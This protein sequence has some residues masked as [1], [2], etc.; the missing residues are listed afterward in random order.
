MKKI[1]II[2]LAIVVAAIVFRLGFSKYNQNMKIKLAMSKPAPNVVAEPV[3]EHSIIRTFE[4]PG[5]VTS[6]YQVNVLARIAGYLEKSYFK[7]GDFVKEGQTLFLIEPTE[8][9]NAA[10][11]AKAN[12]DNIH[13]QLIYAEKQLARASELV[14]K[15]YIAKSQYDNL[16]S[17]RD[18]LKAQL[19]SAQ[20]AY[21]DAQR[22]LGYTTVKSPVDGRIGIITV[23]VGNYV[24]PSS[25]PLT[26]IF[27]TN[28]IYVTFPLDSNDYNLLA[29]ADKDANTNRKVE[30]TF[31]NGLKYDLTG[32]QDFHDNKIDQ[33]TGTVTMRATFQNPNNQLLHG[34]FVTI[35]LYSNKPVNVPVVHQTAVQENQ[36]GKYVYKLDDNDI[37]ELVYIKTGEQDGEFWVVNSGLKPGDMV[38]TDG[39]Q[40]V[41]P[42]KPVTLKTKEEM[43]KIKNKESDTNDKKDK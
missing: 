9:S 17:Q 16:L 21:G 42:G 40:K 2:T 5:R 28:P 14:K 13:S 8:F 26:T 20:A 31:N 3:E 36:A 23:T 22:N 27:S 29:E 25:G 19:G 4:A 43:A 30:L 6:K 10:K 38:I 7:E 1:V 41:T 35:K 18:A 37:P 11:V 32:I 33:S 39:L 15:D 12:V 24:T 34:E